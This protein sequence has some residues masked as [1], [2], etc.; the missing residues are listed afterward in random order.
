MKI[1]SME[2]AQNEKSCFHSI[3]KLIKL[4]QMGKVLGG[5]SCGE[6]SWA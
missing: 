6:R 5:E 4:Y 1:T 2:H 3:I